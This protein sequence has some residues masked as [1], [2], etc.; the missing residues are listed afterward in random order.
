MILGQCDSKESAL[1]KIRYWMPT[2]AKSYRIV[3]IHRYRYSVV[4]PAWY[5]NYFEVHVEYLST[6]CSR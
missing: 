1:L 5:R 6:K 4:H 3:K 2:W